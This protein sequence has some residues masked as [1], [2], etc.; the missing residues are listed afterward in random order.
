MTNRNRLRPRA[1]VKSGGVSY[2]PDAQA[3]IDATGALFPDAVNALVLGIKAAGLWDN[4]LGSLKFAVGVPSLAASLIDLRNPAFNGTAVNSPTHSATA[5][6]TFTAASSQYIDSGWGP[7][8]T[9]GKASLNS[10]HLGFR[11][12]AGGLGGQMPS[13]AYSNPNYF[14]C[15]LM[16]DGLQ[17]FCL[18][19]AVNLASSQNPAA[20]GYYIGTRTASD[21]KATYLNGASVAASTT[22]SVGLPPLKLFI[23]ARN[24][25]GPDWF[26]TGRITAWHAGAGLNGSQAAALASLLDAYATAVGEV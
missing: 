4:H 18:G 10:S 21:A 17:R 26:Y 11:M 7:T 16:A 13:C 1:S 22:P 15:L 5:G 9:D 25:G 3:Y 2:D 19:D 8:S 12:R 23:G 24:A 14:G 20:P 6:W